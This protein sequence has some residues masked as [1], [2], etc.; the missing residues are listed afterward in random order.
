[1][2]EQLLKNSVASFRMLFADAAQKKPTNGHGS[3]I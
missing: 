1:M 2:I 3:I